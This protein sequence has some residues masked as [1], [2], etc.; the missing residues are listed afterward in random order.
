[1][2]CW[3]AVGYGGGVM[4]VFIAGAIAGAVGLLVY[5]SM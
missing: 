3:R 1:M 2:T 4:A 5:L